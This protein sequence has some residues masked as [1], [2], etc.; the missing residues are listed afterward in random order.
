MV[1]EASPR[2]DMARPPAVSAPVH[3]RTHGR[4]CVLVFMPGRSPGC[5]I[6]GIPPAS[7]GN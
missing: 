4:V 6:P 1:P 5:A 3:R 2:A 7:R